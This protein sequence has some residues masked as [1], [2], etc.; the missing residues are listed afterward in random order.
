MA[1]ESIGS[2]TILHRICQTASS[3]VFLASDHRR[4]EQVALKVVLPQFARDA[5]VLGHYAREAS[6]SAS[7]D[8]PSLIKV[9]EFVG[10]VARPYLVMRFI[11]GQ[12]LK[13]VIYREPD[14]VVKQGFRWLV[15]V[16]QA[17]G[18]LHAHGYVHLDVKPENMLVEENGRATLIDLALA[19][20]SGRHGLLERLRLQM[21]GETMGTRSYI[22]PE[23]IENRELGST[24]DIY[25]L[26][27]VMFEM[28]ARRLPLTATDPQAI[29]QLH[30]TAKP[31]MLHHVVPEIHPELSRLVGRMMAKLPADRPQSMDAVVDVLA[32]IGRPFGSDAAS[33]TAPHA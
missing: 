13:R 11:P 3:E 1:L 4:R 22:S 2:Y 8:H 21:R 24:A 10:K 12:T 9:Y 17:L 6:I 5:R 15:R 31:P 18:Y 27:I 14:L 25:S 20:R 32:A 19:R 23:R 33:R 7:L 26:G 28:Y 16:A 29:L 30:L